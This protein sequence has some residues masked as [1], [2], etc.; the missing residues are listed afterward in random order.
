MYMSHAM[1]KSRFNSLP[2]D[3][4]LD[5][6]KLKAFADNN[7]NVAE[8]LKFILG[9]VE[10]IVEKGENAGYKYFLLS[11][12]VFKGFIPQGIKCQDCVVKNRCI[13]A[14]DYTKQV[15]K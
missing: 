11:C 6:S 10:N 12:N 1:G 4:I 2:N 15:A 14:M 7:I 3:K 9:T 13:S 8:K 5:Q